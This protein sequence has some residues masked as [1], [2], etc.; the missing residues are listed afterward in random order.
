M[1]AFERTEAV[2]LGPLDLAPALVLAAV[3]RVL[4][5]VEVRVLLFLSSFFSFSGLSVGSSF[6]VSISASVFCVLM[7]D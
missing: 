1:E 2:S 4:D 6:T 7:V 3:V 5:T